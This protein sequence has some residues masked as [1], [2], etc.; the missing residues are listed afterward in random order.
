VT[1]PVGGPPQPDYFNAAATGETLLPPAELLALMVSLEIAAGRVPGPRDGPRPLDL[2]LL[3]YGDLVVSDP[4]LTLPHP[5]LASRRFVL[6]P[7]CELVPARHVPGTGRTIEEL[8]AVAPPGRV[9]AQG[10]V[11]GF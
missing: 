3:L 4:G 2:D 5:R 1:E 7:L 9:R 6:A 10:R 8:L 11:A